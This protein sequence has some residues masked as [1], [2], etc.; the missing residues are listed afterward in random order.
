MGKLIVAEFMTLDGVAQSGGQPDEDRD[1]GFRHGGWHAPFRDPEA[2]N[3]MVEA[4]KSMD[5][6]L[7]GRRTYDVFAGFWPTAS[8]EMPFTAVLNGVPKYV[9]SRTLTEPLAWQG[10]T[11]LAQPIDQSVAALKERHDEVH[12]IGSLNLVQSLLR[13]GLVDRFDLWVDPLVLGT[14]KKVFGDGIPPTALRLI[15]STSYSNG[16]LHLAYET[17]GEPTYGTIG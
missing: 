6:L 16:M 5:A 14:G 1:G 9:P 7:L 13:F 17:A 10:S 15:E 4:A 11:L 8:E 12:V 2:G 3:A